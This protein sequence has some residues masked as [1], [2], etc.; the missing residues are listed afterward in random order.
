MILKL[1]GLGFLLAGFA[2]MLHQRLFTG[3]GWFN[4]HQF[5]TMLNHEDLMLYALWTGA[6][7]IVAGFTR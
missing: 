6:I 1:L 7:L 2:G 4:L 3:G 5:L